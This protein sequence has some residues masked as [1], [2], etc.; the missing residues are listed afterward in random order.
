M[1]NINMQAIAEKFALE[2]TIAEIKALG[3]GFIN[4]TFIVKTEGDTPNY[5]LQRTR[6][7][8]QHPARHHT[9]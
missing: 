8:G 9:H 1:A 5:I 4:D 3:D 7:D 6:N 2:G